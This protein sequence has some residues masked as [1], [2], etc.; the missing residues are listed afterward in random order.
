MNIPAYT[1][2]DAIQAEKRMEPHDDYIEVEAILT[3]IHEEGP[4]TVHP[5]IV[6]LEHDSEDLASAVVD[7]RYWADDMDALQEA[8][9]DQADFEIEY[10]DDVEATWQ[11]AAPFAA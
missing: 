3:I 2:F 6:L 1:C 7:D 10:W 11:G 5:V 4:D 9:A 8:M